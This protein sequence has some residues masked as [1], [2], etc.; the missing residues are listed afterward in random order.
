MIPADL[1]RQHNLHRGNR[2]EAHILEAI[3]NLWPIKTGVSR[4]CLD[5]LSKAN[6][7]AVFFTH[8]RTAVSKQLTN[9]NA[10]SGKQQNSRTAAGASRARFTQ[11]GKPS[12]KCKTLRDQSDGGGTGESAQMR[13][14][15]LM[16]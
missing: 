3:E 10:Q 1:F 2:R 13:R 14:A 9:V 5:Y 8:S 4:K 16:N 12:R 15:S 7:L 6:V 11:I